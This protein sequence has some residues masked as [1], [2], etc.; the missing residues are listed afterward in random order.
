[1]YEKRKGFAVLVG[2]REGKDIR[3]GETIAKFLS[4]DEALRITEKCLRILKE[5]PVNVST[6]IDAIGVIN[7][8]E[9]LG[10]TNE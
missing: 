5:K 6:I 10:I 1:M 8:K 2:G 3:L 9:M 7:F 4:E